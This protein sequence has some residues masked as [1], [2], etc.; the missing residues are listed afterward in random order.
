MI[1]LCFMAAR[2]SIGRQDYDGALVELFKAMT[3]NQSGWGSEHSSH[4][5]SCC[6]SAISR[7]QK[8]KRHSH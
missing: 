8:L 6:L 4:V 3:Y 5:T 1:A 2:Q 7:V